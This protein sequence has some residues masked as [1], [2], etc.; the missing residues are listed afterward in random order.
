MEVYENGSQYVLY[1]QGE[2]MLF[3]WIIYEE[4]IWWGA[5]NDFFYFI[6]SGCRKHRF[7]TFDDLYVKATTHPHDGHVR[8]LHMATTK[9]L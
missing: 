3:V 6:F 7:Q 8:C 5:R 1:I 4:Q 9:K 2:F